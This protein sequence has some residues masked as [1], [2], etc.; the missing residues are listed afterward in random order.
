MV[1]VSV[2][3]PARTPQPSLLNRQPP[4]HQI[5]AQRQL[6]AHHGLA[7]VAALHQVDQ[8]LLASPRRVPAG[9][10]QRRYWPVSGF[11]PS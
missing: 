6:L 7:L 3:E 1:K 2:F 9:T 11:T 8:Q 4:L 5:L 10:H